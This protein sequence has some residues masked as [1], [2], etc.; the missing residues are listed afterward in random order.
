MPNKNI[1]V[2]FG[3]R[4]EFVSLI[5]RELMK[6]EF[7]TYADVLAL[8]YGRPKGYY[9]RIACNSEAG[10]GELKKAFPDVLRALDMRTKSL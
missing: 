8:Y 2:G 1:F 9:N 10:Y 7:L 6:R 3:L 5:Y 4:S